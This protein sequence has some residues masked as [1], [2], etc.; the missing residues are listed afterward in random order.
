M[1]VVKRER[2]FVQG[3]ELSPPN[4]DSVAS[5]AIDGIA[6]WLSQ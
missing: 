2:Q 1:N 4:D 3:A 5:G 6:V